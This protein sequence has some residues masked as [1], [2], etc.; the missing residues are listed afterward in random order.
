MIVMRETHHRSLRRNCIL[1][2][3]ALSALV[4]LNGPDQLHLGL[5]PHPLAQVHYLISVAA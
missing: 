2:A 5:L 4:G 3:K 1:V